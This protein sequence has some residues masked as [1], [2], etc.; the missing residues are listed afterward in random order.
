M[1][2][3]TLVSKAVLKYQPVARSDNVIS[4]HRDAGNTSAQP[5]L[6]QLANIRTLAE[7]YLG[8]ALINP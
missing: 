1:G 2:T 5:T 7:S 8:A 6:Q 3:T 4:G